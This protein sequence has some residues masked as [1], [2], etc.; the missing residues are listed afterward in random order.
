MFP[1][2]GAHNIPRTFPILWSWST[3]KRR[4][5]RPHISHGPEFRF[6]HSSSAIASDT[7]YLRAI[8]AIGPGYPNECSRF[9]DGWGFFIMCMAN[10]GR[11]SPF[12]SIRPLRTTRLSIPAGACMK[13]RNPLWPIFPTYFFPPNVGCGFVFLPTMFLHRVRHSGSS[14]S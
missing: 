6:I 8:F 4:F 1:L 11:T 12:L 2:H 9:G 5:P 3:V 10:H 7:S 14:V 13:N